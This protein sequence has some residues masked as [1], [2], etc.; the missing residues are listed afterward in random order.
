[1]LLSNLAQ[2]MATAI[3]RTIMTCLQSHGQPDNSDNGQQQVV[4]VN[5][6]ARAASTSDDIVMDLKTL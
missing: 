1:M 6:T 3:N 4:T 5:A 2:D